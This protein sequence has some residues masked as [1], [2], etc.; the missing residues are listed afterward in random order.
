MVERTVPVASTLGADKGYD[1]KGFGDAVWLEIICAIGT[2]T[3]IRRKKQ[4]SN[5][6]RR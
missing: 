3:S 1:T 6:K 4:K 5:P 2:N